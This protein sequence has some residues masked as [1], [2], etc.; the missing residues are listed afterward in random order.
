MNA[1]NA[2]TLARIALIPVFMVFALCPIPNG[3]IW[4]AVV[5]IVAALSDAVDGKVA[6]KYD[7]VTTTGKFLDPLADKLLIVAA[8]LCFVELGL[9]QAYLAMI[10]IARELVITS[11][12][13]VAMGKG[14]VM[15]A[16]LWGKIKTTAQMIAVITMLLEPFVLTPLLPG[17]NGMIGQAL[18]WIATALTLY[19]GFNYIYKN[20]ALLK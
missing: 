14:T 18:M 5:F 12:R 13:I 16:D 17:T 19:S 11:F 9:T 4:A 3:H 1:A 15:A 2:I 6:R 20:R 8:L 7:L 10:I